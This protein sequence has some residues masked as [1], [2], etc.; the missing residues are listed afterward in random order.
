MALS[1]SHS[2]SK[3]ERA[4]WFRARKGMPFCLSHLE[5]ADSGFRSERVAALRPIRYSL[6]R[7]LQMLNLLPELAEPLCSKK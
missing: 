4:S 3:V 5:P 6:G 1:K 2:F 7:I